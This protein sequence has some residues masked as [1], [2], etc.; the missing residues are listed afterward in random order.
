MA[1]RKTVQI[2]SAAVAAV[3]LS[4]AAGIY[5]VGHLSGWLK[6]GLDA[7]TAD[8]N[9]RATTTVAYHEGYQNLNCDKSKLIMHLL[10]FTPVSPSPI[11]SSAM[12][13]A[14]AACGARNS[15]FLQ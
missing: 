7:A 6:S 14:R 12:A 1:T 8:A 2:W 11:I 13:Q 5:S 15:R 3:V 10:Q 4:F 9:A